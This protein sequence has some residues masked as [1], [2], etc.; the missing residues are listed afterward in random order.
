MQLGT[1]KLVGYAGV[2]SRQTYHHGDLRAA[3]LTEAARLVAERGA[4]RVSL[5]ELAREAGV[6]HAAP[7]HHFIDRRGLFTALAAQGFE[8]LAA[9]L[10]EA[11]P[12]FLAAA[13][14]YVRF[15]IEH[16]GHYRVMFD[17]SLLDPSNRELAA[18]EAAAGA[19]LSR[20]VASL[21]DQHAQADPAGA[22][23]AAWSLVH[24]FSM[25][26]LDDAVNAGVKAGDPMATV[27]RIAT[28]LFEE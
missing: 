6:S 26:W 25:L 7:A 22:Q 1:V 10:A 18:A 20:G 13:L 11:R 24:G 15:A 27:E 12:R 3:I 4:D 14:A 5:R 9:A 17:K 19:E 16:P 21:P 8:L 23:L 2:M 28:M